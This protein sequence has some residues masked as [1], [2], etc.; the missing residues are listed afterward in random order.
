MV[1]LL[2]HAILIPTA[3]NLYQQGHTIMALTDTLI[4]QAKPA[5]KAFKLSG[6]KGLYLLI[7]PSGLKYWR[8]D[9]RFETKRQ[10]MAIGV[11]L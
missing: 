6:E 7:H 1:Y 4:R 10:T 5:S 8:F 9:Y 3:Q 11:Y 2:V